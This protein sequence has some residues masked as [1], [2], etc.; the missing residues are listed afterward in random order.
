M[1]RFLSPKSGGG[2][3]QQATEIVDKFKKKTV[4]NLIMHGDI[5]SSSFMDLDKICFILPFISFPRIVAIQIERIRYDLLCK[6]T[7]SKRLQFT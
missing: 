5:S 2:G 7:E 3:K 1:L 4:P 6:K